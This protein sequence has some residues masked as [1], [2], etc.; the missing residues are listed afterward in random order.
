MTEQASADTTAVLQVLD[1]VSKAWDANDA[2]AFVADYT[3]DAYAILP[4]SYLSGKEAVR[5]SMA[6]GFAGPLKGTSSLNNVLKTQLLSPDTAIVISES[7]IRFPGETEVPGARIGLAT[8]VLTKN[9]GTWKV[10][11]YHNA[12][13]DAA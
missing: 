6:G 5:A 11:A 8:W 12:P 10:A 4:G 9:N 2:D 7:G 1:G 13:R 3:Q